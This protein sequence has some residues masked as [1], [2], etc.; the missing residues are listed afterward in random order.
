MN[1]V[2]KTSSRSGVKVAALFDEIEKIAQEWE[3][4]DPNWKRVAKAG[5][6]YAIGASLGTGAGM[7]LAKG[8]SHLA[9]KMG[10]QNLS[11]SKKLM[12]LGPLAGAATVASMVA[13]QYAQSR[14]AKAYERE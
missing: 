13:K 14:Q 11:K 4:K 1:T 12:Y 8:V 9:N 3:K 6:G 7:L 10:Y 5:A 2:A